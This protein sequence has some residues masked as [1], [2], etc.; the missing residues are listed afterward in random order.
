VKRL[1]FFSSFFVSLNLYSNTYPNLLFYGKILKEPVND[2]I[3]VSMGLRELYSD[4]LYIR[5]LQYYGT[6]EEGEGVKFDYGAGE[7]PLFY[8]K[9]K[10]IA[11]LNPYFKNAVLNSAGALAFNLNR[12]HQAISVLKLAMLYDKNNYNYIL[13]L[14]AIVTAQTKKNIYDTKILNELYE[15]CIKKDSPVMLIQITAFISKKAGKYDMALSLYKL[16]LERSKDKFYIDNA[17][18]QIKLLEQLK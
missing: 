5:L 15:I 8:E 4:I 12:T 11:V 9:A 10:E 14:S 7:Y 6:R 16:I 17:K 13:L 3:S 2:I 18:K 1:F